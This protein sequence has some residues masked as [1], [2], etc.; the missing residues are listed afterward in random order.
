[1]KTLRSLLLLCAFSALHFSA[2]SQ[3]SSLNAP[4]CDLCGTTAAEW[5][6]GITLDGGSGNFLTPPGGNAGGCVNKLLLD[7]YFAVLK[8]GVSHAFTLTPGFSGAAQSEY[9]K[10]WIDLNHDGDFDDLSD[11]VFAS[12]TGSNTIVTGTFFIPLSVNTGASSMRIAMRRGSPPPD[13]GNFSN[14]QVL[15][16]NSIYIDECNISFYNACAREYIKQVNL[17]TINNTSGCGTSGYQDFTSISTILTIGNAYPIQLTPGF[18]GVNQYPER[19]LVWI[20]FNSDYD[21]DDPG[22]KVFDSGS[23]GSSS[24]ITGVINIPSSAP[25]S[26]TRMRIKMIPTDVN[27]VTLDPCDPVPGGFFSG[28]DQYGEAEDYTVKIQP[29]G[30][31]ALLEVQ[32]VSTV[33]D[34]VKNVLFGGNC[35]DITNVSFSGQVG[36]IGTFSNAL[37]NIGFNT[38]L[39]MATGDISVAPGP[40]N[41]DNASAGYGIGTPDNDLGTLTAGATFDMAD[42]E[43]DFTPTQ[44]PFTFQF[45]FASEEYCEY[46]NSA[47]NDV[48]GFFLSG[49]GI[50]GVQNIALLPASSTP[51]SINTVNH[52]TNSG[53]YTNNTG[54]DGT[55]CGQTASFAN[56]VDEVQFDGFTHKMT[57][58][59]NVQVCQTYHI[60]LKIADVGDGIFDSAVFMK[61]GSFTEGKA[62]VEFV[63]NGSPNNDQIYEGCGTGQLVFTR[64]GSN[65]NVPVVVQ[66]SISGSATPGLDY[67]AIPGN[68]VIPAGQTTV[69]VP[70]NIL[71]DAL[72]EGQENIIITLANGCSCLHPQEILYIN[73]LPQLQVTADTVTICGPGVGTLTASATGG[74]QPYIY[75]WSNGSTSES[76]SPFVSFSTTYKVT[77]TDA[78]GKTQVANG[79][80][81]VIPPPMAQLVPPASQLCPGQAG[82]LTVNFTGTG[83]FEL[84]YTLNNAPQPLLPG[85]STNP[86]AL[87]INQPGL[88]QIVS[89]TDGLGCTGPGQGA[90]LVLASTLDLTGVVT[91]VQCAGQSSGSINTTVTYG[92]G[93]YAYAWTG[94]Q[95]VPA[96]PDPINLMAG[97]YNLIVT[98]GFGCQNTKTYL[99]TQPS[100]MVPAIM[101]TVGPNCYNPN[102]GSIDLSMTGGI[103]NYTYLWSGGST[104]QDPQNLAAGTYT[105]TVTDQAMCT[106][107]AVATVTGNF[108]PPVASASTPGSLSC[109]TTSLTLSGAGSSI[110]A[111]Y[112]YNWTAAPGNITGGAT[113]PTPTINQPGTYT[114]QVTNSVNGCTASAAVQVTSTA[115]YPVANFIASTMN[116]VA[117]LAVNFMNSS[118]NATTYTWS[119]PGGNPNSSTAMNPQNVVFVNPGIYTVTLTAVGLCGSATQ[120][121]TITVNQFAPVANFSSSSLCVQVGTGAVNF[122]DL[123]QNTPNAWAWQFPGGTPATSNLPNPAVTYTVPGVYDVILTASNAVGSS[124][125]TQVG[126][127]TVVDVKVQ[128]ANGNT[129]ICLGESI[130]LSASGANNF[131]W[132]GPPELSGNTGSVV[133][134]KP[135]VAGPATY[136]IVGIMGSCEDAPVTLVIQVNA[137]PIV[138]VSLSANEICV[139]QGATLWAQGAD[140]YEWTGPGLNTTTGETVIAAPTAPGNY[141]YTVKGKSN[142]CT[143]ATQMVNLEVKGNPTVDLMASTSP[144]CQ[145]SP[146]TLTA[147]GASQYSSWTG[148]G[149]PANS[150][151]PTVI[152]TPPAAGIANYTVLGTANNGCTAQGSIQIVVNPVP[153]VQAFANADTICLG[154]TVT[155][156]AN[157]AADYQWS[158]PELL[159]TTGQTVF[160]HPIQTGVANYQVSGTTDLCAGRVINV[161][162]TVIDAANCIVSIQE[163][164]AL[165]DIRLLPNPNDGLFQLLINTVEPKDLQVRV[166]NVVGQEIFHQP[167]RVLAGSQQVSF[168]L[169]GQ[170]A[171]FYCLVLASGGRMQTISFIK[172]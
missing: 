85:I 27:T 142:G 109:T 170:P 45:V 114:L 84:L 140:T 28:P 33:E 95:N 133:S 171:G 55:L 9:W 146:E 160:A 61:A 49:P 136:T 161:P 79:R 104:V 50:V 41:Q 34:L 94:P 134:A 2:Q 64:E 44:S 93:P 130:L 118:V 154:D 131:F 162:V 20:D 153:I 83:P 31:G 167:L 21:F 69:T 115:A 144:F 149:L 71:S 96:I 39:V 22:E 30:G 51:V 36:Q 11:L 73:D 117:P 123:S 66:Y 100:A 101:N 12:G 16:Y 56:A 125:K 76:I 15:T 62:S 143:S 139:G 86:Y 122:T 112:T 18:T 26:M 116:G 63:V 7:A 77:V 35:F 75:Q 40:N 148:P 24:T 132:E 29:V 165:M 58:T 145:G 10:I 78:C 25:L 72:L 81:N 151:G 119:F 108:T 110:G 68:V 54:P 19:W 124:T 159:S 127:L 138:N 169:R 135:N 158:G 57:A 74:V 3:Q 121:A 70:V 105:V 88:Y 91:N 43:F 137:V 17:Q 128:T 32:E 120:T 48:F 164:Q 90:L 1:M 4:P 152:A 97:Q 147:S 111:G 53:Y 42:I 163:A 37:T 67:S 126:F 168:E 5:I 155:L 13:C 156:S 80:I 8:K 59:A 47:F 14:G 157:G 113:T 38:G 98:D 102:G 46:V 166:L 89:V 23:V 99:V 92:Q 82:Q 172:E 6:A 52:L 141:T 106:K 65:L 60:K 87:I 107:T 129:A 150:G 103:P